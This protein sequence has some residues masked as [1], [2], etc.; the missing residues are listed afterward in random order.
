MSG[1]LVRCGMPPRSHAGA[2]AAPFHMGEIEMS[3]STV[4]VVILT[5]L[6]LA[7]VPAA[8]QSPYSYPWCLRGAKG[9]TSCYYNSYRE[10]MTTLSG[11]GGW[12]SRS[13]YYHGPD[14]P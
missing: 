10:C 11:R 6:A 14:R 12:C 4:F 5:I 1:L 3:Q 2:S 8:A 9:S 13:P 7:V